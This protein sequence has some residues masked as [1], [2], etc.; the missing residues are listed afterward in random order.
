MSRCRHKTFIEEWDSVTPQVLFQNVPLDP[1]VQERILDWF[2][3][4]SCA[5]STHEPDRFP[6]FFNRI[7][8]NHYRQFQQYARMENTDFD[9]M[10]NM[11]MERLLNNTTSQKVTADNDARTTTTGET[12]STGLD[13]TK[14][15][16]VTDS[17]GTSRTTGT[18]EQDTH[19]T[20]N[21]KQ[22]VD[23]TTGNK[24]TSTVDV[25]GHVEGSTASDTDVT[26]TNHDEGS[27]T[28]KTSG[29]TSSKQ[30][31]AQL[32][33]STTYG[34]GMPATLTWSATSS[35]Q[36]SADTNTEDKQGTTKA[37]GTRTGSTE[38]SANSEEDSTSKT[39]GQID[40]NGTNH[41]TTDTE[42]TGTSN[43]TGTNTANTTDSGKQS[44]DGTVTRNSSNTGNATQTQVNEGNTTTETEASAQDKE[45]YSGRR[46]LT[47]QAALDEARD[48]I[49]RTNA[50]TWYLAQ[51]EKAFVGIHEY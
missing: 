39:T 47:P 10:V 26:E 29:S 42:D 25:V 23:G 2:Y 33:N 21:S 48:Y 15:E 50:F 18:T 36:E 13:T 27:S 37:D 20:N 17:E 38:V 1:D 24:T 30:L 44:I 46:V 22:T 14:T 40:D 3:W 28:E 5:G 31:N 19:T 45:R 32:P 34:S 51:L 12:T 35:Q 6:T 7:A 8:R 9:P 16:Q 41:T 4:R 11:Y 43:T 49:T